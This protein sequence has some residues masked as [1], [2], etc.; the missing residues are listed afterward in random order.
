VLALFYYEDL[1]VEEIARTLGCTPGK[2]KVD[3]HRARNRLRD[4]IERLEQHHG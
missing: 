1:P 4:Q 2:V 3:L